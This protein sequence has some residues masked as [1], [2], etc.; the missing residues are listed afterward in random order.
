MRIKYIELER[1]SVTAKNIRFAFQAPDGV[2]HRNKQKKTGTTSKPLKKLAHQ[3]KIDRIAI[4]GKFGQG[5]RR[6]R[7]ARIMTTLDHTRKTAIVMSFLAMNLER[8]LKAVFLSLFRRLHDLYGRCFQ[9]CIGAHTKEIAKTWTFFR[10][11]HGP[12]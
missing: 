6:D 5:K 10:V 4:E 12:F 8:G 11:I 3:D 7:P 2:D 9:A 1:T